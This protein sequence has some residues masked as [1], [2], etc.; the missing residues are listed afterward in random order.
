[1]KG[2]VGVDLRGVRVEAG[3]EDREKV[4]VDKVQPGRLLADLAPHSPRGIWIRVRV[5][6][7]ARGLIGTISIFLVEIQHCPVRREC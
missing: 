7:E 1:M 6:A 4:G 2:L 5:E 3:V